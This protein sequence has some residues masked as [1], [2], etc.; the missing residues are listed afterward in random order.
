MTIHNFLPAH[1]AGAEIYTYNLARELRRRHEVIIVYTEKDDEKEQYSVSRGE[2]EGIPVY[3]VINNQRYSSFEETYKNPAMDEIFQKIVD[4]T[5]PDIIH[6][7]HLMNLSTNFMEIARRKGIPTLFTLHEYW[8]M[9]PV[10]GHRF[11][12]NISNSISMTPKICYDINPSECARCMVRFSR[13]GLFAERCYRLL[14]RRR[15]NKRRSVTDLKRL[16]RPVDSFVKELVERILW[17]V[18]KTDYLAMVEDRLAHIK[19]MCREVDLFIAPSPFLRKE[20]IRFGIP[21]EK[22]IYSDYGMNPAYYKNIVRRESERLRFTFI[23]SPVIQKGVHVLVEAF[24]AVNDPKADLNIYG[25]L[26]VQPEYSAVLVKMAKNPNIHFRGRFENEK[27]GEIL[28]NTDVLV[29][30]SIW[31]ENSPLTIHEAFIAGIPVITSNLGGM[32]DL[33]KDGVSGLLF[34]VGDAEDLRAKILSLIKDPALMERL[35][36]GMPTVKTIEEDALFIE[37]LY[38][39][40]IYKS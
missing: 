25:D 2:Y 24:N 23:G 22:I 11:K 8:L 15:S 39:K 1:Q 3:R 32:A 21:E 40:V 6:F 14:K 18:V 35:T 33:V 30:P 17:R 29:V 7:Q 12:K 34:H 4:E 31:F 19:N 28:S 27:I 5:S 26:S 9:C 20:F 10:S 38:A 13:V 37:G 16:N 36:H